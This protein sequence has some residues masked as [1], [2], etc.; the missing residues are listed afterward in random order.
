MGTTS[1][2][3][4]AF[5]KEKSWN[6]GLLTPRAWKHRGDVTSENKV[7]FRAAFERARIQI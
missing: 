4:Y 7:V 6:G 1:L 5:P 3:L 2:M